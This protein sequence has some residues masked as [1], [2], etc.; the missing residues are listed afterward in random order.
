MSA[1]R[2]LALMRKRAFL[3]IMYE[4]FAAWHDLLAIKTKGSLLCTYQHIVRLEAR[5]SCM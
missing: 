3:P 1:A 2:R 5:T 4:L